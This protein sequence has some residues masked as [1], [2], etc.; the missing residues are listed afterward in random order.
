[1]KNKMIRAVLIVAGSF[2]AGLGLNLFLEPNG[3]APGGISGVAVLI[4]KLAGGAVPVGALTLVL[5]IPLFIVGYKELGKAFILKSA[6][7]TILYSV[8][9]DATVYLVQPL[10]R[11]LSTEHYGE[12]G[13][14]MLYAIWGGLMMGAGLGMIFRGGATTGGTDIGARL[15]QR[16][17]SWMTLG[18]LVLSLDVLFLF[19]VAL[20][21]Q[22]LIAAMYT[23]I[24]VFI[25]SKVIDVVE[26]GVNY[27]K[28]IYIFTENPKVMSDEI[29]RELKRGVTLLNAEGMYT[30]KPVSILWCVVYN[31]Q[32]PQLRRIVDKHDPAAFIIV[33]EVRETKGLH[34]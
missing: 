1:M 9:I 16:K 15:L 12:S 27:A 25:S 22:S 2:I 28:E 7:G 29:M 17:M 30:G 13:H 31:R 18:Q 14:T 23:G 26:A 34:E 10:Q 21:Y 20:I 5:N 19:V 11:F 6:L 3:I 24:A 4:D 8:M 32:V 33:N